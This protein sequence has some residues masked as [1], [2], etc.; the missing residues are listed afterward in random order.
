MMREFS[1]FGFLFKSR[2]LIA[3]IKLRKTAYP[4]KFYPRAS[5][6]IMSRHKRTSRLRQSRKMLALI[7]RPQFFA[8]TYHDTGDVYVNITVEKRTLVLYVKTRLHRLLILQ[9]S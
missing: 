2:R 3:P 5:Q 4:Y 6:Q 7:R 8:Q 1:I 9:R